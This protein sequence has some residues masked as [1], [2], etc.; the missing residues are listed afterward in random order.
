MKIYK[1]Y[2]MIYWK[3]G[4]RPA[5]LAFD[6][7]KAADECCE[8]YRE[9]Y[10]KKCFICVENVYRAFSELFGVCDEVEAGW[11]KSTTEAAI[12]QAHKEGYKIGTKDAWNF[13]AKIEGMP[14]VEIEK[15]FNTESTNVFYE[16]THE[17]A[18]YKYRDWK[19]LQQASE[20]P[21]EDLTLE[22][23]R[24]EVARLRNILGE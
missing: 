17:E 2:I 16:L 9:R 1:I 18:L 6:N 22:Q 4:E 14:S 3:E 7:Y 8:Y 11:D 5:A 20:I 13:A 10:H 21:S 12:S 23:A 15:I 19:E 24:Y